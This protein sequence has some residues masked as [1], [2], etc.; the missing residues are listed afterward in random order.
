M[1]ARSKGERGVQDGQ[2][3]APDRRR[4]LLGLSVAGAAPSASRHTLGWRTRRRRRR[5][6]RSMKLS[7]V[8]SRSTASI[9]PA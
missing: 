3:A 2:P 5:R 7:N 4:M 8:V 1:K 6:M 9:S